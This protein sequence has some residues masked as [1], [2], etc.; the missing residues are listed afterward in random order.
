MLGS[1]FAALPAS[2]MAC[3]AG[4]VTMFNTVWTHDIQ[5]PYIRPHQT[6]QHYLKVGRF[7]TVLGVVFPILGGCLE[8]T[9]KTS[10]HSWETEVSKRGNEELD[11]WALA[12]TLDQK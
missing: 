7:A 11:H 3:M 4:N 5:E 8:Y 9:F 12:G 2:L 10:G 1:G 6:G